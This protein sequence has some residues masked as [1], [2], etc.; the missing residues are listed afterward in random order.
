MFD[1]V[2]SNLKAE[3][4]SY[5]EAKLRLEVLQSILSTEKDFIVGDQDQ[6]GQVVLNEEDKAI[7]F[8]EIWHLEIAVGSLLLLSGEIIL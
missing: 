2:P 7:S 1:A 6:I 8:H 4:T 3:R 5:S